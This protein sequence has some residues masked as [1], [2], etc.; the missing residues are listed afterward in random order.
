MRPAASI[1]VPPALSG[2]LRLHMLLKRPRPPQLLLQATWTVFPRRMNPALTPTLLFQSS[3]TVCVGRNTKPALTPAVGRA[4]AP[5]IPPLRQASR[6]HKSTTRHLTTEGRWSASLRMTSRR[7]LLSKSLLLRFPQD[8]CAAVIPQP[9]SLQQTDPATARIKPACA[10]PG[11]PTVP[12]QMNLNH[13]QRQPKP[14]TARMDH[15][16]NHQ[17][18]LTAPRHTVPHA[19]VT[20]AMIPS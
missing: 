1:D 9:D 2:R 19:T 16:V 8:V 11:V 13:R 6:T 20:L 4:P 17:G 18:L 10:H 12:R 7:L 5:A 3:S 15:T 14:R